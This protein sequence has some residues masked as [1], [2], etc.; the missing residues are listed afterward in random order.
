MPARTIS[1]LIFVVVAA[2]LLVAAPYQS[3][4]QAIQTYDL[5]LGREIKPMDEYLIEARSVV[6]SRLSIRD[7]DGVSKVKYNVS[8][9]GCTQHREDMRIAI[10]EV[11][12]ASG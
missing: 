10:N 3:F 1:R 5:P 9:H 12:K 7:P 11:I 4:A 8:L 6:I 2:A